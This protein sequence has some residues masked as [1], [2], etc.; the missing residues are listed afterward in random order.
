MARKLKPRTRN[1]GSWTEAR[2]WGFLRSGVRGISVRWRPIQKA[3]EDSRRSYSGP[4][5]RRKWEYQCSGCGQ[6]HAGKSVKVDHV[7]PCGSLRSWDDLAVFCERLFCEQDGLQVLCLS[8][9]S[10]KNDSERRSEHGNQD[11]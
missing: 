1:G 7:V 5:K 11:R 2:F 9:H 10:R 6:W 8:C 4:D 3:K